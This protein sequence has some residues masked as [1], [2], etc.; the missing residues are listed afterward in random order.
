MTG[1]YLH[2]Y[3]GG[4]ADEPPADDGR[5]HVT[6]TLAAIGDLPERTV[7][8]PLIEREALV[9]EYERAPMPAETGAALGILRASLRPVGE[10]PVTIASGGGT[11]A[12][13]D[14]AIKQRCSCGCG[15]PLGPNGSAW[16]ASDACQREWHARST[17]TR[18][19]IYAVDRGE[20]AAIVPYSSAATWSPG[21]TLGDPTPA[22]PIDIFDDPDII[23]LSI[24][25]GA[26]A[27]D[28]RH[29]AD[30]SFYPSRAISDGRLLVTVVYGDRFV[31]HPVRAV[32][33]TAEAVRGIL[34]A[35][36]AELGV[37]DIPPPAETFIY[38]VPLPQTIIDMVAAELGPEYSLVFD[39]RAHEP[40]PRSPTPQ[41]DPRPRRLRAPRWIRPRGAR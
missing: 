24:A 11:L 34:D 9:V 6:F 35:C 36:V 19:D 14:D 22:N 4:Y 18:A 3:T 27:K 39:Y 8:F 21:L 25:F 12:A 7:T 13:I 1:N 28:H 15:E 29:H 41:A 33:V 23:A 2:L 10:E 17:T 32:P 31:E 20:D 40:P 37:P 30:L 26:S 38:Q 16:F 5:P